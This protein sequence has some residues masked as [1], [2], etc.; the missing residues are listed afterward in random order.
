MSYVMSGVVEQAGIKISSGKSIE[1]VC[2]YARSLE[3]GKS[4]DVDEDDKEGD[5]FNAIGNLNYKLFAEENA[6]SGG[7]IQISIKP[8]H[9]VQYVFAK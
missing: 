5:K 3:L 4:I 1:F 2:H 9:N 6:T 7:N 8:L